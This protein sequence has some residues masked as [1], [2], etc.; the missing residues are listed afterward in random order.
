MFPIHEGKCDNNE[1]DFFENNLHY[2]QCRKC[3]TIIELNQ[4]CNHMTCKCS[5]QFCY[6]CGKDWNDNGHLCTE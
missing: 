6:I 1:V 2:R 3:K 4:G 5:H